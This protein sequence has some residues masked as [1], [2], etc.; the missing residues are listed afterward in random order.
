MKMIRLGLEKYTWWCG[1]NNIEFLCWEQKCL[2]NY[3]FHC[4]NTLVYTVTHSWQAGQVSGIKLTQPHPCDHNAPLPPLPSS[5][6]VELHVVTIKAVMMLVDFL[7]TMGIKLIFKF[8]DMATHGQEKLKC[9]G[10]VETL[11][12]RE[13]R[14]KLSTSFFML[15]NNKGFRK[16]LNCS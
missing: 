4:Y 7:S 6:R 2:W 5:L 8:Q 11:T 14:S 12:Q 1:K 9:F 15:S 10:S 3:R 16:K 13:C